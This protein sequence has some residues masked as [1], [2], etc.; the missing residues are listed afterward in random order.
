MKVLVTG[1]C[2]FI[3]SNFIKYI[4][5]K[6]P[7][8]QIVNLDKLTYAANQANLKDLENNIRYQF[9]K[10]DICDQNL[11]QN[12]LQEEE[13][14]IIINFAA[15]SHVDRSL[16]RPMDFIQ[17]NILGTFVLLEAAM[18]F[19]K[20]QKFIQI[21]TDEVYGSIEKGSFSEKDSLNPSSPY[22]AS[23]AAADLLALS[24]FKSHKLPVIVTRS[25]N[26]FGPYQFPEKFVPRLITNG[27]FGHNLP[28]FGLGKNIR[29]WIFVEDHC[30]AIDLVM[31]KG[32]F[33]EIYNVGA[34]GKE[35]T[36]LAIAQKILQYFPKSKIEH[37]VDRPGHDFRYSLN[38]DKIK[39]LG[40]S[41]RHDFN[42]VLNI[43]I[44]WYR[45]N[46]DWW[47]PLKAESESIYQN[48]K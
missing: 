5:L 44:D 26:N 35:F 47:E 15:E 18:S 27:I 20:I 19:G 21:G 45:E 7:D 31:Q 4:L 48:S 23:K 40:F 34:G 36:N 13:P 16:I 1:G 37:V 17:T 39:Y 2:G 6:Y 3:G 33:G 12:I 43:T 25:T 38:F 22:S 29:D 8:C 32:K 9:I 14:E 30:Q 28:I 41:L 11:V 46:E 42:E 10:G 24:Y